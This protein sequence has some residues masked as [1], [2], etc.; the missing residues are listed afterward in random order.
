M[1]PQLLALVG[2]SA[3]LAGT[4]EKPEYDEPQEHHRRD[5]YAPW[6]SLTPIA[7]G[8]RHGE[9]DQHSPAIEDVLPDDGSKRWP[10]YDGE[11]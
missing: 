3:S 1:L 4:C 8:E 10:C 5:E 7:C 11:S 9:C 2:C 6:Q